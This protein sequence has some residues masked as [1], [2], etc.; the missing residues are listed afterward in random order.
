MFAGRSER[1]RT[2]QAATDQEQDSSVSPFT[3]VNWGRLFGYL[4]P[5]WQRMTLALVALLIAT[6]SGLAFPV[7]I[8]WLL[9]SVT[10]TGVS[11]QL[12]LL[13]GALIDLFCCKQRLTFYN[14]IC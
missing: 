11:G 13:A 2:R 5:Y 1:R 10:S 7:L 4:R 3:A 8:V 14:P 12:N 9:D 6:G